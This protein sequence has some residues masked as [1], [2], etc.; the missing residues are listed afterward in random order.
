MTRVIASLVGLIALGTS[1]FSAP[2]QAGT[3]PYA[4]AVRVP[5]IV[6]GQSL[7]S[8]AHDPGTNR[9]YA[10]NE[11]GLFWVDLSDP[12]PRVKGPLFKKRMGAIEVAPETGRL[13][14]AT[15]DEIGMVNLRTNDAPVVLSGP[16]WSLAG[17]VYEPTRKQMY[18]STRRGRVLVFDAET[19][20]RSPDVIV[21]GNYVT[22]L[23]A[24][25]GRVVFTLADKSGLYTIDAA[26]KAVAPWAVTGKLVTPVYLEAD[27]SGKYLFATYDR[28]VV[29]IDVARAAIV[30]RLITATGGRIAFDPDSR[31]L[32][33]TQFEHPGHPKL[34][35]A[36]YRVGD[37]GFTEVS[38]L[39]ILPDAAPGLE[40]LRS[41]G[42]LQSGRRSLFVW[43]L[44]ETR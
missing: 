21:P 13:F 40:S 24:L 5:S 18:I 35:L 32:L 2:Q 15:I 41:G 28:Y 39:S 31:L 1:L 7:T 22:M 8:F 14:Y 34:R 25:P 12:E 30:G 37:D 10:G 19:G 42:F 16:E 44:A 9:L 29:A 27:P 4:G 38:R 43:K 11:Q 36:A 3:S 23:E 33:A 17:F 26:T 6:N 20:E